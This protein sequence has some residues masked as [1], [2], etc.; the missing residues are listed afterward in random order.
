MSVPQ[1]DTLVH[2]KERRAADNNYSRLSK[3]LCK[4]LL[5]L[6]RDYDADIYFLAYRNGRY[7]GFVTTD[8]NGQPWSPPDQNSLVRIPLCLFRCF[9][10]VYI[11]HRIRCILHQ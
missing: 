2:Q 8:E 11:K 7:R 4:K 1:R 5:K 6:F 3:T 10:V 9:S